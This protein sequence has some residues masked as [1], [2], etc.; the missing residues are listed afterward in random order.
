LTAGFLEKARRIAKVLN[1]E[2][3]KLAA[4]QANQAKSEFIA[5]ISH[6]L[7]TPLHAV[8]VMAG[9]G[10]Q[11]SGDAP[12]DKLA[13]YFSVIN[14][15][16]ERLARLVNDLLDI[17]AFEAGEIVLNASL[18]DLN[19]L[20]ARVVLELAS[21]AEQGGVALCFMSGEPAPYLCDGERIYQVIRNVVGNALKFSP[22]GTGIQIQLVALPPGPDG[23]YCLHTVDHGPGIPETELESIFDRFTQSSQT[24]TGSGGSGLGLPICREIMRLHGGDILASNHPEGGAR[25]VIS[26]PPARIGR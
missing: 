3:A 13:R 8:L 6:E 9:M 23:G 19:I 18:V 7:R 10:S 17:S 15:S 25:F 26:F 16:A 12:R 4:E 11:K 2:L 5:N 14:E 1:L 22:E 21:L 24:N 20:P